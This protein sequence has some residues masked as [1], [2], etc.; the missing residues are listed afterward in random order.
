M[1]NLYFLTVY[2]MI[3]ILIIIAIYPCLYFFINRYWNYLKYSQKIYIVS[4]LIKG[5]ILCYLC[6]SYY[7]KFFG[8]FIKEQWDDLLYKKVAISYAAT[9]FCSLFI[10][11]KM[12]LSTTIHHIVVVIFTALI[13]NQKIEFYTILYSIIVYGFFS[14]LSYIVNIYLATRFLFNK[15]INK[16]ICKFAYY[17]YIILCTVNWSYQIQFIYSNLSYFTVFLP[18]NMHQNMRIPSKTSQKS[19]KSHN[20]QPK[21]L[22]N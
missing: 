18:E 6:L 12:A 22:C 21:R 9:D 14:S 4:N 5:G 15:K 2:A 8:I 10:V 3:K 13:I 11:S 16:Q 19:P 7:H 17:S 20:S 1:N